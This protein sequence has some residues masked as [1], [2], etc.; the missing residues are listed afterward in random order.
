MLKDT[1]ENRQK[2]WMLQQAATGNAGLTVA[3]KRRL[4]TAVAGSSPRNSTSTVS[5]TA[6]AAWTKHHRNNDESPV[7]SSS[8]STTVMAS[9]GDKT[10]LLTCTTAIG[11]I[12]STVV[13][14]KGR[15]RPR[16]QVV[17]TG[18]S[19]DNEKRVSFSHVITAL[20]HTCMY[21]MWWIVEVC[22]TNGL[23]QGAQDSI[24]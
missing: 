10:T 11:A 20:Y 12:G 9:G 17:Y 2:S 14:S 13:A 8:D 24:D 6:Q 19:V 7:K 3:L 23:S 22:S 15:G 21:A 1:L 4:S 16:K 5:K 18:P